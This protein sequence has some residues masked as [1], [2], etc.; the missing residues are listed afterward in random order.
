MTVSSLIRAVVGDRVG[1]KLDR[2]FAPPGQC[3]A[4]SPMNSN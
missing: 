3:N 2:P 4:W 1:W